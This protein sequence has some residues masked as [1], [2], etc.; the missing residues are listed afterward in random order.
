[1]PHAIS[2]NNADAGYGALRVLQ[3]CSLQIERGERV[4]VMGKSGAGKSTLLNLIY[5]E[6]ARDTALIPQGNALIPQLSVFHNVYMGG[7]DRHS[8]WY[9]LRSLIRPAPSDVETVKE[10]LGTVGLADSIFVRAG[11]LSGGQQQRVSVARALYNGRPMVIG[12][13]P[14]SALDRVQA[15]EILSLL[16]KRHETKIFALHDARL[17][18]EHADRIL[19]L[20]DGRII[21]DEL[22]A[23]LSVG[24]LL[25]YFEDGL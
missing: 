7:L 15:G 19:V 21:L 22:A 13:E 1:V 14:V 10:V 12:D 24:R 3:N 25:V 20:K 6:Y 17:A 8:S 16:C 5:R 23:R 2:L 11:A 9:N 4:V 18:L